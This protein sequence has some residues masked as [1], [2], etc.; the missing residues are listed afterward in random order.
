MTLFMLFVQP[1]KFLSTVELFARNKN[2]LNLNFSQCKPSSK[3]EYMNK[4]LLIKAE[5]IDLEK[6]LKSKGY[7][8]FDFESFILSYI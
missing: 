7:V 2:S 4:D 1:S 8:Y 5:S 3:F 6:I